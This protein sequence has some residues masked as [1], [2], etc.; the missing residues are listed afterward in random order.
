M[1]VALIGCL[2]VAILLMPT[3]VF[4]SSVVSVG[5]E[6]DLRAALESG[7]SVKLT[8]DIEI[9]EKSTN[10]GGR[11]AGVAITGEGNITIEGNGHTISGSKVRTIL[12]VYAGGEGL[13]VTFS[14]V[15]ITNGYAAGRCI[16]TRTGKIDLTL[17]SVTL[18]ATGT[19]NNQGLTIGGNYEEAIDIKVV[20]STISSGGAGYGIITYNP[21]NLMIDGTKI[22]G[23]GALYMKGVDNSQGSAGSYVKVKNGSELIGKNSYSGDSDNFGTIVFED[24]GITVD[25][26]DSFI[27]ATGSGD[28]LQRVILD[29]TILDKSNAVVISG[30]SVITVDTKE[31][32]A[33]VSNTNVSIYDGVSSNVEIPDSCI[34]EG[35]ELVE[36]S[37]DGGYLVVEKYVVEMPT[38]TLEEEVEEVKFSVKDSEKTKEVLLN[39]IKV[40]E[41]LSNQIDDERVKIEVEVSKMEESKIDEEVVKI[42]KN[43]VGGATIATFFDITIAIKEIGNNEVIGSLDE[44]TEKIELMILL[45]E[46]LRNT[47]ET[48]ERTYYVVRYHDGVAEK[49]EAKLSDDGKSLVFKTDKFSTYALAYEDVKA[50]NPSTGDGIVLYI[51]L[52]CLSVVGLIITGSGIKKKRLSNS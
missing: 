31:E 11:S 30:N 20:D 17:N 44:L 38:A 34:P 39:S 49:I 5:T 42:L 52:A 50:E 15:K 23:Y 46:E 24:G 26:E 13:D 18:T 1:S 4:A 3:Y 8:A 7:K 41:S 16:D 32:F 21:V 35:F 25:I 40:K 29:S 43:K 14:N 48:V 10:A 51:G 37:K 2:C 33:L 19:G 28:A 36:A 45:P 9:T 22:T 47:L 12:E 6:D 27:K